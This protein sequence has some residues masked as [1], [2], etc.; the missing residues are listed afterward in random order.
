M[1]DRFNGK[2]FH[3]LGKPQEAWRREGEEQISQVLTLLRSFRRQKGFKIPSSGA[4]LRLSFLSSSSL[5]PSDRRFA[6]AMTPQRTAF[7]VFRVS[8]RR[9][10]GN[11]GRRSGGEDDGRLKRGG[12]ESV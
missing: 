3:G 8:P 11:G 10:T 7:R 5:G 9:A 6:K 4:I 12:F 2:S 1:R